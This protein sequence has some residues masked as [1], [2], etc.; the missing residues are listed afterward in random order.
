VLQNIYRQE[1]TVDLKDLSVYEIRNLRKPTVANNIEALNGPFG[2]VTHINH[3]TYSNMIPRR[4]KTVT[5]D[6]IGAPP[7]KA[8]NHGI[9]Q[10]L[11]GPMARSMYPSFYRNLTSNQQSKKTTLR[12]RSFS[13]KSNPASERDSSRSNK[14][15]MGQ[16]EKARLTYIENELTGSPH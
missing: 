4:V 7:K 6:A 12:Q 3:E 8:V 14:S 5:V 15:G 2:I 9:E 1:K 10:Q 11:S 13:N 16:S